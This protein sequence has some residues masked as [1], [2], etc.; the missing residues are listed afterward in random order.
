M[1]HFIRL[2]ACMSFSVILTVPVSADVAI[3]VH[4]NNPIESL[5][6][7]EVQRLFLGRILM[8]PNSKTKI[9]S[10]DQNEESPI[11]KRFYEKVV[12]MNATK[13]KKYR[14]FYL[15]SGKGRLPLVVDKKEDVI[16]HVST[17]ENSISYVDSKYVTSGVKV[18]FT[19]P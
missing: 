2:L 7:K 14:A 16:R 6:H 13:L 15:F 19:M 11:F 17:T 9:Y 10:I 12:N 4:P 1:K 5:T 8:F 3:I 18:V